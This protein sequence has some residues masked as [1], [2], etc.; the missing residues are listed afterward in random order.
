MADE[1]RVS[2]NPSQLQYELFVAGQPA[3]SIRYRRLP[4]ALALVHTEVEPRFEGQG[5]GA[6]LVEGAL[7]DIRERGLHVVPICPF[8]RAY[9]DRHPDDRDLI[10]ADR[11]LP[12]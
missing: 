10:A 4:D 6:R 7:A 5:L 1:V 12:D 9:L 8:V 11:G 3:G 2:D